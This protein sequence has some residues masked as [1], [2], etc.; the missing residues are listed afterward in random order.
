MMTIYVANLPN[1]ISPERAKTLFSAYGKVQSID[2]NLGAPT[3]AHQGY[4]FVEMDTKAAGK[5]IAALDGS[6]FQ[7]AI[8]C[9]NEATDAQ[10]AVQA[11]PNAGDTP[12]PVRDNALPSNLLRRSFEVASVE[13]VADPSGNGADNWYRYELRS[14]PARIT[15]FHRGSVEEVTEYAAG[16]A[17]AFNE[18]NLKG[19]SPRPTAAAR[20]KK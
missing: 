10:L 16:C 9:V 15:G 8:L 19:S 13:R 12:E 2:L 14:G 6:L 20:K 5:A 3:R 4:G 17:D 18:R 7:G 1:D 11:E